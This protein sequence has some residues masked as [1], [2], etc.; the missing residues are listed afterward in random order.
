MD[1]KTIR[2]IEK[3]GAEALLDT[4]LSVPLKEWHLP[5]FKKSFHLRVTMR[6]PTLAGQV[7]IAKEWLAMGVTSEEMWHFTKEEEMQF[8]VKHGKKIS[9]MIAY[10]LC[11]G[12]IS[13][14][15]LV[16]LTAWAVR[17]WMENKYLI[18]VI[19]KFVGLMGTDSFI[20]IIK[21]AEA[22]NPMKLRKSQKTKGS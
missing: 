6:R 20:D 12:W 7:R 2:Q 13:R 14:Y 1:E 22:V 3:E 17:N 10:T 19:K 15:L 21:S 9:R 4:G 16:G 5:F 11:R 18:S 8:L